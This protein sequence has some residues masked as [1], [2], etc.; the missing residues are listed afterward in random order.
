MRAITGAE[1]A[2]EDNGLTHHRNDQGYDY[3]DNWV[4]LLH[5]AM[6]LTAAQVARTAA[7]DDHA[8]F[9]ISAGD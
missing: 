6:F 8:A 5:A 1:V 3:G 2:K 7:F 9:T 4:V